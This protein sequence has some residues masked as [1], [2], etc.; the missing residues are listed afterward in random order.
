MVP[1]LSGGRKRSR[2]GLYTLA[3]GEPRQVCRRG[4]VEGEE[5]PTGSGTA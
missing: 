1:L 3:Q 5:S 2:S 4:Q